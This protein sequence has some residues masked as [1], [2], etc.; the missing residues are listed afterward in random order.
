[1]VMVAAVGLASGAGERSPAL[2]QPD[3]GYAVI[4]AWPHDSTAFTEGLAFRKGELYEGTGLDDS[5]LR[6]VDLETGDVKRQRDLAEKYFGE[7]ITL[8]GDEVFQITWQDHRGWAYGARTFEKRRTFTY[9]GEGW[10]LADNGRRIAMSNGT[11][12]IRF[13]RPKTFEAVREIS[14]TDA[15]ATVTNLNELEWIG[16]E[17]F[18]NVFPGDDVVRIDPSTG[19]VT[20]RFNLGEVH[21]QEQ[22]VCPG[23]EVANGIAYMRSE[24]RL[25]VTGKYWCH[26]Y[27]IV[28]TKP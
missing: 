19:E 7:G 23:A 16:D 2:G 25:F 9:E 12:V 18:A 24:D 8:I 4:A 15:G 27:E 3:P 11:E 21:Q 5:W 28:L 10:G 14:V 26:V 13:R 22:A 17:L 6:R 1:M 20:G